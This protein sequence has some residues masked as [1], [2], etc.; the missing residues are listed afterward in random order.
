MTNEM[1]Y[2]KVLRRLCVTEQE[3]R[4][5]SRRQEVVDARCLMAAMLLRQPLMTQ[6]SVAAIL[7]VSQAAVS[8]LLKRHE[9]LLE[10]DRNYRRKWTMVRGERV[11]P[12]RD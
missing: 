12:P 11:L 1:V 3:L 4:S 6:K 5:A 7:G 10:T 2:E 8:H 9:G